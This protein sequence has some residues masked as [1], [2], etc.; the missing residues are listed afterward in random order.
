[1]PGGIS[2][3]ARMIP[4]LVAIANDVKGLCPEALFFNYANPMSANCLAIRRAT[5]VP[6]IGLCHGTFRTERY[7][8]D[9]AGIPEEKSK[10]VTTSRS[11]S[12]CVPKAS[13]C[14]PRSVSS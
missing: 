8:A 12:T 6:V 3:A 2:R 4:A 13:I 11:F 14:C 7:L 9:L 10:R 1:M 5:G